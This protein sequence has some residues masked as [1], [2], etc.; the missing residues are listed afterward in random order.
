MS[1]P[2]A[3]C[4]D[5]DIRHTPLLGQILKVAATIG[6][7]LLVGAG[8]GL[9]AAFIVGTGG[10]GALVLSAV[11]GAVIGAGLDAA[12]EAL[13][14]HSLEDFITAPMMALID[15]ALPGEVKGSIA[16]GSPN[17]RI[18]SRKAARAAGKV[19]GD[20]PAQ[21]PEPTWHAVQSFLGI[22][23]ET[24]ADAG[25]TPSDDDKVSCKKHAPPQYIA[26]GS[27]TVFINSQPAARAGDRTTCDAVLS[28]KPGRRGNVGIGGGTVTVRTIMSE[29]PGWL[30]F[31]SKWAGFALAVCQALR[32]RGPLLQKVLC[33][34]T[35]M[36]LG[37][38]AGAALARTVSAVKGYPVHLPSGNKILD[39]EHDLDFEV[40]ARLPLLLVRRYNAANVHEGMFGRGW[41]TRWDTRLL[42]NHP[43]ALGIG[44]HAAAH[45]LL[46]E[47]GRLLPLPAL[48]PGEKFALVQEGLTFA[49]MAVD[50]PGRYVVMNNEG[51]VFDFD[52]AAGGGHKQTLC[53]RVIEDTNANRHFLFHDDAGRLIRVST[54]CGQALRLDYADGERQPSVITLNPADGSASRLLS[55]YRYSCAGQL[56]EVIDAIPHITRR[57]AYNAQCL[58][59]HQRLPTGLEIDYQWQRFDVPAQPMQVSAESGGHWRVTAWQTSL[60]ERTDIDYDLPLRR[61][62]AR[63]RAPSVDRSESWL[64]DELLRVTRYTD[65]LGHSH[66]C[67]WHP[68]RRVLLAYQSPNGARFELAYD[69]R[70]NIRAL[71]DPQGQTTRTRWHPELSLPLE[72][73]HADGHGERWAYDDFG[74][75]CSYK[76]L[77]SD[78]G[79]A[80]LNEHWALD[81]YGQTV[82][83]TDTAGGLRYYAYTS[84][85]LLRQHRDCSGQATRWHWNPYG[86][87]LQETD[88]LGQV[89]HWERDAKGQPLVERAADG[90]IQRWRWGWAGLLLEHLDAAGHRRAWQYQVQGLPRLQIDPLGE[91]TRWHY[92]ALGELQELVD[93]AGNRTRFELD[94]AGRVSAQIAGDGLR[95]ELTLDTEG[96]P[97][98]I[99]E[100]AG[101]AQAQ[102]TAFQRDLLGRLTVKR[103]SGTLTRYTY[104]GEQ[105][106]AIKRWAA[107]T[108]GDDDAA[109]PL[110]DEH[111]FVH[112][113]HGRLT[114]E[115]A[116]HWPQT[117]EVSPGSSPRVTALV[118]HHDPLGVR[119]ATRLPQGEVLNFL[120]YGAGHLHQ[121]NLDG[122]VICDVERDALHREQQRSQGRLRTRWQRDPLGRVQAQLVSEANRPVPGRAEQ[123]RWA[124]MLRPAGETSLTGQS[125]AWRWSPDGELVA[126]RDDLLGEQQLSYDASGRIIRCQTWPVRSDPL[127][128]EP[129]EE[130][131]FDWD[132]ASNPLPRGVEARGRV[133]H[134][135]LRVFEDKRY[136]YDTLGRLI[137]KRSG[138]HTKQRFEWNAEHQLVAV[139]SERHGIRQ[140]VS[141]SYDALGRRIE[142]RSGAF[143]ATQFVWD[144]LRLLQE[145][146]GSRITTLVYESSDSYAPMARVDS[147]APQARASRED[148]DGS[149]KP[150]MYWFHTNTAGAPEELTDED[151]HVAW[152]GRYQTWGN[153]ALQEQPEAQDDRFAQPKLE[154]QPIR[155]QGQYADEEVGLHYN[156]FRYYDPD[157]GRFVSQDPIGLLGGLNLYA[158]APNSL[159]WIDPWGL[160]CILNKTN[161]TARETRVRRRLEVRFGK[162]NV[163]SERYLR[164]SKGNVVQDKGASGDGTA[165][166]PDFHVR[167]AD[168]QWHPVEVTSRTAPKTEQ[169]AKELRIRSAGGIFIRLPGSQTLAPTTGLSRIIRVK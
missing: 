44:D 74:N 89:T 43:D 50:G 5:D 94:E 164:D 165:R 98:E 140:S 37:M 13:T 12:S 147:L 133:E 163:V 36:G 21:P 67:S 40:A 69:E 84:Q 27:A 121:V 35:N 80:S 106:V 47:Q 162:D 83:H 134:N 46:D 91:T 88:A 156:T 137:L 122:R 146:Q 78:A 51:L 11:V 113:G 96:L 26:Q 30:G 32:G 28:V 55:R 63:T 107:A 157:C 150:R 39:G 19:S 118:H 75:L 101:T 159:G 130:E 56:I 73:E 95:T 45:A 141:F 127:R 108:D 33:F 54:S 18:N 115:H 112:D 128:P 166:R 92:N 105:L 23:G 119:T 9:A 104:G 87:L 62:R 6:V 144:G 16:T 53:L 111:R 131:R 57:F 123:Q 143:G 167:L 90:S 99:L 114:Q 148:V 103:T 15:K 25:T 117:R 145:Q 48:A 29:T 77:A 59:H 2:A 34:G 158:Y 42:L 125:K 82:A 1:L 155:F 68:E 64:W 154:H 81:E 93:P 17:V 8:V 41:T 7:G 124:E 79:S 49:R 70:G 100:A 85:G 66:L 151:G 135:R 24:P 3:A 129:P 58:M 52:E 138:S 126:R 14:G 61:A 109:G 71:Q 152:R 142:K 102:R 168:G 149:I 72:R 31:V 120:H 161:G 132:A 86:E 4:I 76:R 22:L 60:G 97:V 110:W 139:H 169:L 153:L 20:A 116:C 160:S 65:P 10:L 136:D 38:V